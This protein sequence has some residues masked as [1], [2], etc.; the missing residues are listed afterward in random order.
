MKNWLKDNPFIDIAAIVVVVVAGFFS[1]CQVTAPSLLDP[2][3]RVSRAQLEIELQSLLATAEMRFDQIAQ[4]ETFRRELLNH[5]L[6]IG[7]AGQVNLIGL[8]PIALSLLG[9]GAVADNVR[10]RKIINTNLTEYVKTAKKDSGP[11]GDTT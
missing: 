4:K 5:A 10:K 8:I 9:A 2:Q 6:V 7:Q 3:V 1:G 11:A